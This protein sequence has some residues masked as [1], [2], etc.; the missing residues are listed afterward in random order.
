MIKS[1]EK[2]GNLS[3]FYLHYKRGEFHPGRGIK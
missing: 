2:H 3:P 1:H